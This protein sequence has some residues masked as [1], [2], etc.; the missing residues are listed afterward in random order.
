VPLKKEADST[1][2]YS[3]SNLLFDGVRAEEI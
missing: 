2:P 1:F 3:H